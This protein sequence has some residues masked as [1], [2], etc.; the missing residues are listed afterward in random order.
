MVVQK[1]LGGMN[2]DKEKRKGRKSPIS[3]EYFFF[4]FFFL[5]LHPRHMSV[6]RLG[7]KLELQLPAYNTATA[8][9]DP[10]C[11]CNLLNSLSEATE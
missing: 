3:I 8:T 4:F 11:V 2:A 10:S 6:P 5:G 7:V 1:A 9:W